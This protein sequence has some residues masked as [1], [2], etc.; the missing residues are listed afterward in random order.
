MTAGCGT[1][2]TNT[3]M[4]EYGFSKE[5]R[6]CKFINTMH[7]IPRSHSWKEVFFR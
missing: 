7:G 5:D 4:L 3:I 6:K 1:I 2:H